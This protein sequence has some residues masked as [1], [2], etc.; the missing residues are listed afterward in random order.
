MMS[1][2]GLWHNM[3]NDWLNI[4]MYKE[5]S[6]TYILITIS[7]NNQEKLI[8]TIYEYSKYNKSMCSVPCNKT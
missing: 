8:S 5:M 1:Y 3:H 4:V 2:F 6:I 7:H